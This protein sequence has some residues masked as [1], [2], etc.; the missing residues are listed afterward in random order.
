MRVEMQVAEAA[1]STVRELEWG[2]QGYPVDSVFIARKM[3]LSVFPMNLPKGVS[4]A[5]S[6]D[7]GEDAVIYVEKQT[8]RQSVRF[9]CAHE[10][11]HYVDSDGEAALRF[12]DL[13][14]DFLKDTKK[15][16]IYANHFAVGL[17]MPEDEVRRVADLSAPETV[18]TRLTTHFDVSAEVVR[19]RL[20]GLGITRRE[21]RSEP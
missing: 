1:G 2:D 5:M 3:G 19:F 10:L 14:A 12:V 17:L 15:E 16:E 13:F 8:S 20:D 4:G 21:T 18:V 11:G 6:K 9:I 7:R